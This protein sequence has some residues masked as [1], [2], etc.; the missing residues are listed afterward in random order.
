MRILKILVG[1]L[2]TKKRE[3]ALPFFWITKS[4]YLRTV[5]STRRASELL[6]AEPTVSVGFSSITRSSAKP[7]ATSAARTALARFFD[8]SALAA[9]LPVYQNRLSMQVRHHA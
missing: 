1:F 6:K 4:D 2:R 7:A 8:S 9:A 3:V 5:T